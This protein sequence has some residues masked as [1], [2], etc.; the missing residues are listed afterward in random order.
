MVEDCPSA[1][2][3]VSIARIVPTAI[4]T[5][6]TVMS[7]DGRNISLAVEPI[8]PSR[9]EPNSLG[10]LEVGFSVCTVI[11]MISATFP[12]RFWCL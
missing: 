3:N 7:R 4:E 12:V 2:L 5:S 1:I 9:V 11:F 6:F 10:F 8:S